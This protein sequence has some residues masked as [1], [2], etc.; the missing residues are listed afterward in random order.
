MVWKGRNQS[1][2]RLRFRLWKQGTHDFKL[3]ITKINTYQL[4]MFSYLRILIKIEY[5]FI[6]IYLKRIFYTL[7]HIMLISPCDQQGNLE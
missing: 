4:V 1:F 2:L 6:I 7:N 3:N 5:Y